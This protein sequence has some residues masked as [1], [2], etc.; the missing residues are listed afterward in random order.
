MNYREEET[1]DRKQTK[2]EKKTKKKSTQFLS[3]FDKILHYISLLP[4][5]LLYLYLSSFWVIDIHNIFVFCFR[6]LGL[7]IQIYTFFL[8]IYMI[9]NNYT[10]ISLFLLILLLRIAKERHRIS[11]KKRSKHQHKK[12][13]MKTYAIK[14]WK[15]L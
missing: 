7:E 3:P 11:V 6:C 9:Y 15:I 12:M 8:N 13:I 4:I 2:N 14:E 10:V 5:Y 1:S